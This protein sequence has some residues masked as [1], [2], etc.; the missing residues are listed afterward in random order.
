MND[1][2]RLREKLIEDIGSAEEADRLLPMVRR[3]PEWTAPVPTAQDTARLIRAVEAALPAPRSVWRDPRATVWLL[4]AQARIVQAEIWIGSSL[5]MALGALVTALSASATTSPEALPLVFA[6]P[7]VAAIGVAFV[8]GPLADP[9][10]EIE[11]A[12][13][14]SPRAILLARLALLFGFDLALGVGASIVLAV[15]VPSLSPWPLIDA[16]LAPMASLS[17]LALFITVLTRDSLMGTLVSLVLWVLQVLLREPV[18]ASALRFVPN[19]MAAEAHSWLWL[20]A[21]ALAGLALWVGGR[22]ERWLSQST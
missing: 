12:T 3:L 11:L 9:S 8:Y 20:I 17:A 7:I 5:V 4:R 21:L 16:W 6:A 10:L 13:P 22:E 15:L 19:W 18:F 14:V 2:A 1:D